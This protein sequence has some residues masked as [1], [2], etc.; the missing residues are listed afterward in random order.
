MMVMS[1]ANNIFL[2]NLNMELLS[3]WI[4]LTCKISHQIPLQAI[5]MSP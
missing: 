5:V 1:M 2:V 4:S 3:A